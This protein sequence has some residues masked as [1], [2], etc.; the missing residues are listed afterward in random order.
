MCEGTRPFIPVAGVFKVQLIYSLFAQRIEN[1]FNVRSGGGVLTAD[2]DRI[3][4]VF[5]NWWTTSMRNQVTSS[6]SLVTIIL[7]ALDAASSLH[8]E[9]TS[10]WTAPGLMGGTPFPGGTT[11]SVK[12]ATG[13]RGRSYRGRIYWPGLTVNQ[14][15]NGLLTTTARDAIATSVNLLRTS[16]AA[17]VASDRLVVVSYC[18]D[19]AWLTNGVATEI[20]SASAH[21]L[22]DSQRRRL[23]GRGL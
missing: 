8:K 21:L 14:V 7:D 11:T 16:L 3:E 13:I 5:A 19:G 18:Q 23:I 15:T 2:A 12:L 6:A 20:T 10:G 22:V 1:V 4:A 9:Y 17:D